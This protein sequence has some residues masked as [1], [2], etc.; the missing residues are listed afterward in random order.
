[1]SQTG[2]AWRIDVNTSV[3]HPLW[4]KTGFACASHMV[5]YAATGE[6]VTNH[7]RR[8]SEE[9]VVLDIETAIERGRVRAGGVSQGVLVPSVGWARDVYWRSMGKAPEHPV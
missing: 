4:H 2:A 7:Y 9:V 1:M 8:W 3:L 6:L 5:L